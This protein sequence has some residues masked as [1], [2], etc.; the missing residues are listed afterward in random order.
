M[1]REMAFNNRLESMA[2]LAASTTEVRSPM[3]NCTIYIFAALC[4]AVLATA[5]HAQTFGGGQYSRPIV[6]PYLNLLN[7]GNAAINYYGLV[8][9]QIAANAA[10]QALG[11]NV[12]TLGANINSLEAGNQPL[13]TGHRSSFMTQDRYFMTN[14][15]GRSGGSPAGFGAAAQRQR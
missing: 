6:S 11:A 4:W 14:G 8:R 15:V 13:Q 9:P 5:S 7:N 2:T 10:F 3:K 1:E 12:T